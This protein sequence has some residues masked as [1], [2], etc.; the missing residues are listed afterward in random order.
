ME[1]LNFASTD[2]ES[3]HISADVVVAQE[4]IFKLQLKRSA[5]ENYISLASQSVNES[6]NNS[7][8]GIKFSLKNLAT[9]LKKIPD[10]EPQGFK[11]YGKSK[12]NF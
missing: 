1:Q 2:N 12:K 6:I 8:A 10:S 4:L 11:Y 9:E 7:L 5:I 3:L